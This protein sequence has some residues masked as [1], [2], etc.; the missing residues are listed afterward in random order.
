ME[1]FILA[2]KN[3][4][5]LCGPCGTG[6][7]NTAI[8]IAVRLKSKG[9]DVTF[10][11]L[12]LINSYF[13]SSYFREIFKNNDI[14]LIAPS[15]SG[16]NLDIPVIPSNIY[17]IFNKP[18]RTFIIDVGGDN[19]GARVLGRFFKELDKNGYDML[20]V[21]NKYCATSE[22]L[23]LLSR[24]AFDIQTVSRL[25][26]TGI[27]N[28]SNLAKYTKSSHIINSIPFTKQLSNQLCLPIA[29]NTALVSLIPDL[30]KKISSLYP[31]DIYVD[32][33]NRSS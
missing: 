27:I 20:F 4:L 30:H 31:V 17:S 3:I 19:T 26:L 7:T 10:I 32:P 23:D 12:D 2:K 18:E 28:N 22:N 21:I 5:I 29:M 13:S 1:G 9:E 33:W 16:S 8:N 15:F 11:D 24:K 6:K 25:K 14:E